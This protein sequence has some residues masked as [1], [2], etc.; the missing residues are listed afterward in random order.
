MAFDAKGKIEQLLAKGVVIPGPDS[1]L[2]GDEVNIDRIAGDGVVIYNGCKI[3]GEKTLIM[4]G[5]RIGYEGPATV[6]DC[7]IG[8]KVELKGGFFRR[9]TFLEKANIGGGAQVR[10]GCILEEEAKG[11][12]TVGLKQA[13]LF[14]FV[15]LGSLINFCDC[16]MA[17][18]T[19]RKNHSEVGSSYIH[20]N[21]TPNQDKATPAL[22][23][24]VPRGVM[25]N[26]PPI[27]L[28]GQGGLVGPVR[29]EYGTV[30][31]AGVVYR[32]DVVEAGKLVLGN[33]L[34]D[35]APDFHPGLYRDV[36]RI[37]I[38]NTNYLANL[39]AL[40]H[41]YLGV[42]SQFFMGDTM[43]RMLFEGAIEKLDLGIQER[44]ERF[45]AVS[46]KMP[47]SADKYRAVMKKQASERI[48]KQKMA[49]YE[50]WP[51]I[52]ELFQRSLSEPGDPSTREPFVEAMSKRI[53]E[54]GPDYVAAI[55]G[56]NKA[57]SDMGTS[58]LQGIVDRINEQVLALMA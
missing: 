44:I 38:N 54:S 11:A 56:L 5:A 20:F 52:E 14:P 46:Q 39:I 31:A 18:G 17:G 57:W 37:A 27:F 1:V 45:Q 25:L 7:Q 41:W 55:Q 43:G 21:Y 40:R 34:I 8:P 13:I 30:I 51:K 50:G 33:D 49:L 36:A 6:D 24:D 53:A 15:T 9:S 4:P 35:R 10:D 19:S 12:H 16:L 22:I 29:I 26:Q 47:E 23:G 58:W 42:R 2:V 3:F 32:K 28:G 48:L